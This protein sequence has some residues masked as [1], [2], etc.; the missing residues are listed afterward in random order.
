MVKNLGV[1]YKQIMLNIDLVATDN[2]EIKV[3]TVSVFNET[4]PA[5][6]KA[7]MNTTFEEND[8]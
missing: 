4:I 2:I 6:R 3:N 8:V 1:K 5:D 7:T